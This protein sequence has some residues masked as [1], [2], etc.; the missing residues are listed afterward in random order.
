MSELALGMWA[1]LG[2]ADS[3]W[4]WQESV[5]LQPTVAYE[6]TAD[7]SWNAF[8]LEVEDGKAS[9]VFYNSGAH[10]DQVVVDHHD[11]TEKYSE[12]IF[13]S[14]RTKKLIL[15]SFKPLEVKVSFFDVAE[16]KSDLSATNGFLSDRDL[17]GAYQ[18]PQFFSRSDWG[19][20]EAL[21]EWTPGRGLKNYFRASVPEARGLP[22]EDR[23]VVIERRSN[24]GKRLTW[25]IEHSPKVQ[26]IIVHHT[27]EHSQESRDPVTLIRAIYYYHTI[28]RGW[29]DIG[30]N[31][32]IDKNGN[33]YEGRAGGPKSVG[34][35]TAYHNAGSLGISLMGNFNNTAPTKAQQ[36]SLEILIAEHAT[37]YGIDITGREAWLHATSHNI[38]GH[39][40]VTVA[41]H[42]TACPGRFLHNLLPEI[43]RNAQTLARQ[44]ERGSGSRSR[45]TLARHSSAVTTQ[46]GRLDRNIMPDVSLAK[47]LHRK[48]LRRGDRQTIDITVR[49]GTKEIWNE[50]T[51][52]SPVDVPDGMYLSDFVSTE[53]IAPKFAGIFRAT[54]QASKVP[55]GTYD[56]ELEP[57]FKVGPR[58][59]TLVI[60]L[61]VSG[62]QSSLLKR[63]LRQ[64]KHSQL[65]SSV[66]APEQK[67]IPRE[68]PKMKT[69]SKAFAPGVVGPMV[70][71][72]LAYFDQG[73]AELW[74]E[75]DI[76]IRD[77]QKTI[78]L[79]PKQTEARITIGDQ[80]L[81]VKTKERE[82][83]LIAPEFI[84]T[85]LDGVIEIKNYDR[86]LGSR[87]YN[88][89]RYRLNLHKA[90]DTKLLIVNELPLELYL[91]GLSEEPSTEPT[92]KKHA[93]HILARSYALTYTGTR[94]K[95][96]TNLY[97]LEDSPKTS[98]FYL[99]HEW[100]R[101]HSDQIELLAETKGQVI[102]YQNQPVIGP[103]FTQSNG[104][105]YDKWR[106]Q[107]PWTQAQTLPFDQGLIQKGHGVGLSG[108]TARE[109]AKLGWGHEKILKYFFNGIEVQAVY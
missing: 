81:M 27:A 80:R 94:R 72:K 42:G 33:I 79:I 8:A 19:A 95:F 44:M 70:K 108:N 37:R 101:Y 4:F 29:G 6:V 63:N 97:D 23:P 12:M 10:W 93:I 89:F 62:D 109:L 106:S 49:N 82:W 18:K 40:D 74:S 5:S 107:Y 20:D 71:I 60:P 86:G 100:E 46:R 65:Q 90:S 53:R 15:K 59:E 50:G 32:L 83:N 56:I 31:Y 68:L 85:D 78:G 99:G 61:Q 57:S 14:D 2:G 105:T 21:R 16:S 34:A 51:V 54:V 24:T 76:E 64:V 98:Q 9:D 75:S 11:Q 26:K 28:T 17:P 43:R 13:V 35:H 103:Y 45:D 39:R 87:A 91:R 104:Q 52:L 58:A 48:V 41:G 88:T 84:T 73:Y 77:K 67:K 1:W 30:Y 47:L 96:K 92:A 3:D 69:K 7:R 25:P 22:R 36:K 102:T 66:I 38:S 55:N